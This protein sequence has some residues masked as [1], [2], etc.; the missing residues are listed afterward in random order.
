MGAVG[1][2]LLGV[3]AGNAGMGVT[4]GGGVGLTGDYLYG[5]PKEAEQ[6]AEQYGCQQS[7]EPRGQ[8]IGRADCWAV[9]EPGAVGQRLLRQHDV[10]VTLTY[11]LTMLRHAKD[12][13]GVST[14][15]EPRWQG[16]QPV[17]LLASLLTG[18]A[19]G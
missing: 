5:K 2:A 7:R 13:D 14:I 6:K 9:T 11:R 8:T 19:S 15:M 1:G 3:M 16:S 17:R 4:I 18:A 12:D 10:A